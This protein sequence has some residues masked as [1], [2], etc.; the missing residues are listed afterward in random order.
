MDALPDSPQLIRVK[1]HELLIRD[2]ALL[3]MHGKDVLY[4]DADHLT[5]QGVRFILPLF[6][7]VFAALNNPP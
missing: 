4:R 3:L 7:P 5:L 2:G 1:P 6:E